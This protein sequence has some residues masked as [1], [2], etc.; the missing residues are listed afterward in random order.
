MHHRHTAASKAFPFTLCYML[1]QG[2]IFD[3]SA[4][5]C[6]DQTKKV[7]DEQR[8]AIV[9]A[10]QAR[11]GLIGISDD[12]ISISSYR[13]E[14]PQ[15]CSV[16]HGSET[17]AKPNY[18]SSVAK[19]VHIVYKISPDARHKYGGDYYEVFAKVND[20][21]EI[22]QELGQQLSKRETPIEYQK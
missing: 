4:K 5:A 13:K 11:L 21:G 19:E 14:N 1:L 15:C 12:P 9:L 8:I 16:S 18:L 7:H 2:V 3:C 20:C 6:S 22:E 10:S 17:L